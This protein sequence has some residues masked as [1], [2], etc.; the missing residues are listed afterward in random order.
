MKKALFAICFL[1]SIITFSQNYT[2]NPYCFN[3]S[4]WNLFPD[5]INTFVMPFMNNDSLLTELSIINEDNKVNYPYICDIAVG[6][7]VKVDIVPLIFSN[8]IE[9][10]SGNLYLMKIVSPN[11]YNVGFSFD[12]FQLGEK[13]QVFLFNEERTKSKGPYN[14]R[15]NIQKNDRF[16]STSPSF[17]SNIQF[18]EIYIPFK[19]DADIHINSLG[20]DLDENDIEKK[21]N[22]SGPYG[23]SL[24][25]N[26]NI[27]CKLTTNWN[28]E[29]WLPE[30]N[31]VALIFIDIKIDNVHHFIK[32]TGAFINKSGNYKED[33]QPYF[34]TAEHTID[35]CDHY[36][37]TVEEELSANW[38]LILNY[39]TKKSSDN[40]GFALIP[41]III[42]G[43]NLVIRGF[44][45][46]YEDGDVSKDFLLLQH[47]NTVKDLKKHRI[48]Y[49]GWD[50]FS[51][52]SNNNV[53]IHHP[54]GDIKKID[55]D[56]DQ[57]IEHLGL[58]LTL[59][60]DFAPTFGGT[61][62]A[63]VFDVHHKLIGIHCKGTDNIDCDH[64]YQNYTKA[65]SIKDFW[66]STF[67]DYLNPLNEMECD[68]WV[69]T[70]YADHCF[71]CIQDDDETGVDCGGECKPCGS[72][73][74][75]LLTEPTNS[76]QELL[77]AEE[78]IIINSV[79]DYIT[80]ESG[81]NILFVASNEI[82]F[83]SGFEVKRGATF[84]A[85]IDKSY[86]Y[87]SNCSEPCINNE[88]NSFCY[89][90]D[91]FCLQSNYAESYEVWIFDRW[92]N[93][94]ANSSGNIFNGELVCFFKPNEFEVN[95]VYYYI[96]E[97][98]GCEN[99]TTQEGNFMYWDCENKKQYKKGSGL[100]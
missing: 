42:G 27:T 47:D 43:L 49:A 95:V 86:L 100:I 15:S 68:S 89:D 14:K 2:E 44:D 73:K 84:E 85:I 92:D 53:I 66:N 26:R 76:L 7:M 38:Q 12:K 70:L 79:N 21:K 87:G 93:L 17:F 6:I 77:Y 11:A 30:I 40:N 37:F 52:L 58:N 74:S 34:L 20:H 41:D 96:I 59:V 80:V 71:N 67:D 10:D 29:T 56:K 62:G 25:C 91:P 5:S 63:P 22:K 64:I 81:Q 18:L 98:W 35:Y 24:E 13:V 61:S 65:A 54:N 69:P 94:V 8:C 46:N 48:S 78:N 99:S 72:E 4:I 90:I 32:G 16:I 3:D 60:Y 75:I 55:I 23:T 31:S 39:Q 51:I 33:D 36:G 88:I 57:I 28:Y 9:L 50:K 1:Q 19:C 45:E 83:E 82:I 97:L